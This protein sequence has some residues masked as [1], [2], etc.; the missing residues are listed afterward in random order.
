MGY[1]SNIIDYSNENFLSVSPNPSS[2]HLKI[3]SEKIINDAS[4]WNVMGVRKN[5]GQNF[6]QIDVNLLSRGIYFFQFEIENKMYYKKVV[7]VE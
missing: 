6:Q 2:G 3:N 5:I 1:F 7:V 4:Y